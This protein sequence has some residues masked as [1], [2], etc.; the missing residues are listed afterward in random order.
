MPRGRG[1]K[2]STM[3][4]R[5]RSILVAF[6]CAA[7]A[8][9]AT[10]P[11]TGRSQ[12]MLVSEDYAIG[13][14][15]AAYRSMMGQLGSRDKLETGTARAKQIHDITDRLIAQ[16]VRF[17][18]DSA[19]WQWQ[20]EVIDEPKTINAFCM[21]GGKMGI[22]TGFWTKLH[23]TD[24]ELA[25]VMGHEIAH[26]LASHPREG[27]STAIGVGVGVT[28]LAALT[29]NNSND[30]YRNLD[31]GSIAAALAIQLPH[32]REAESEADQ[33]GIELAAR[34]GFNPEAAVTL[35]QKMAKE[36]KY[37]PMEFLSTHPA[38]ETRIAKLQTLV[39]KVEPLYLA[40]KAQG[41]SA[42]P[43]FLAV[44]EATNERV[45]IRAGEE[46]R[47]AYA[48][49][50]AKTA[51][52]MTFVADEVERFR[53]GE[54][55]LNCAFG[56]FTYRANKGEW[57]AYHRDAAWRELAVSVMRADTLSDLS[58]F[59]LAE[60]ARGLGYADAARLYYQRALD[61]ARDGHACGGLRGGCEGF[62]VAKLATAALDTK[63]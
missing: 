24:D 41:P 13:S 35:W 26:A 22:Y 52:A 55:K 38:A 62:D 40:A 34:A 17:R 28:A 53:Q 50:T 58:Y 5:M 15:A 16:A 42:V 14:S 6:L 23:A 61:A 59:M 51:D 4:R 49:R 8:G 39:S 31:I 43:N 12:F 37:A 2:W 20:I 60:A 7:L 32:S 46:T 1:V 9:C 57:A 44:P 10:N 19:N 36:D 27:I 3:I 30:F 45:V 56:C 11:I 18:P 47:E 48:R 63:R 21:A 29:S 54:V 25:Q 33:I